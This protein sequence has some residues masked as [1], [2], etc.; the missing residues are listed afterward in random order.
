M[1]EYEDNFVSG[2]SDTDRGRGARTGICQ[3]QA[4]RKTGQCF[5][6]GF[7]RISSRNPGNRSRLSDLSRPELE[8]ADTG[9]NRGR[10]CRRAD[11]SSH[12]SH[13]PGM[14]GNRHFAVRCRPS[15]RR[16]QICRCGTHRDWRGRRRG[17]LSSQSWSNAKMVL[18]L[19]LEAAPDVFSHRTHARRLSQHRTPVEM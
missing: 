4:S 6:G 1:G 3:K 10:E 16:T 11:E 19:R 8:F 5:C 14:H 12:F 17:S 2:D 9:A 13:L 7:N 18:A 15:S